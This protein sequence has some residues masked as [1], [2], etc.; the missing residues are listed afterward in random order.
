MSAMREEIQRCAAA[1][2]LSKEEQDY[3]CSLPIT[4]RTLAIYG[5]QTANMWYQANFICFLRSR[6]A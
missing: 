6:M 2:K 5:L 4:E 3:I 1:P